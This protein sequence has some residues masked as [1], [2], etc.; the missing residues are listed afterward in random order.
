MLSKDKLARINEL[1][2]K[3]KTSRLSE[4][5][6]KEQSA[7]RAEYLQTFRSSM[8]NTLKGVTIVDP[9]GNDVTPKKLK[10]ERDKNN[11]H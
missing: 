6:A 4:E 3:A 9:L 8:L 1:A 10:N 5:E 7:L 11:L 2:K